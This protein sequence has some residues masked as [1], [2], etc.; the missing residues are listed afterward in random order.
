MLFE[1]QKSPLP[2]RFINLEKQ[3]IMGI[4]IP[5]GK[6]FTAAEHS[7]IRHIKRSQKLFL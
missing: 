4:E 5:M 6:L 2:K 1:R 7:G 3:G